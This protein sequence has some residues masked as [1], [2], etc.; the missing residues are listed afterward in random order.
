MSLY[1]N[2]NLKCLKPF[3][4]LMSKDTPYE[5]SLKI[6]SQELEAR[7]FL[8]YNLVILLKMKIGKVV[9]F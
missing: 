4:Y 9:S 5:K 2:V 6:K 8:L 7:E 1:T 3:R